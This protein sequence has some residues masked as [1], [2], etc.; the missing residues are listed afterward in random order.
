MGNGISGGK[1][2]IVHTLS[3]VAGEMRETGNVIL[4]IDATNG[5]NMIKR[6]P[7]LKEKY[8]KVPEL[9][10]T[11]INTYRAPRQVVL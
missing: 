9:H 3:K 7:A 10:L 2:G 11:S 5:R 4:S 6:A 1:E 8:N